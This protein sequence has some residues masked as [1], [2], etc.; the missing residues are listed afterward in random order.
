MMLC[1]E[2]ISRLGKIEMGEEIVVE[3]TSDDCGEFE[4]VALS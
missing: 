4:H 3:D 2:D 1:E